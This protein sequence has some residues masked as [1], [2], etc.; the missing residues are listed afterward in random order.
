MSLRLDGLNPL[1][2]MGVTPYQPPNLV[3]QSRSPVPNDSKNVNLGTIWMVST[4]SLQEVWMLM[5]LSGGVATWVQLYP[6]SGAGATEFPTDSGTANEVG[7]ILNI[8][9]DGQHIT[10]S[11]AGNTVTIT[12]NGDDIESID[13]DDGMAFPAAGVISIF[14]GPN[15]N[16][17]GAGSTVTVSLNESIILPVTSSD[18]SSGVISINNLPFMHSYGADTNAFYGAL[19]GNFTLTP[20]TAN[21]NTGIGGAAL[22]SLTDGSS[23]T[24][25]GAGALLSCTTGSGNTTVGEG[26]GID[27][28]TGS[29][30]IAV[31]PTALQHLTTGSGNICIGNNV[32][33]AYTSSESN[34]II[35]GANTGVITESDTIRV[36]IDQTSCYVQGIYGASTGGSAQTVIIDPAGKLGTFGG[37][38]AGVKTTIYTSDD[39][40]VKDIRTAYIKVY[41]WNGGSGGGSGFCTNGSTPQGVGGMGGPMMGG[42]YFEGP[43]LFFPATLNVTVGQGGAGGASQTLAST[44]GNDGT[45]G[46]LSKFGTYMRTSINTILNVGFGGGSV[47]DGQS[48]NWGIAPVTGIGFGYTTQNGLSYGAQNNSVTT[49]SFNLSGRIRG[50][51]PVALSYQTPIS[52]SPAV[53]NVLMSGTEGGT[54]G[55]FTPFVGPTSFEGINGGNIYALPDDSN[56]N[57]VNVLAGGLGGRT[58][59]SPAYNGG[60][61]NDYLIGASSIGFIMG[62]TGGGG[63]CSKNNGAPDAGNGGNGG[64]PGGSGGGGGCTTNGSISG[65]GGDGA[66]GQVIV[67]E[68]F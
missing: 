52:G 24:A 21:T 48:N 62:G 67:L 14:G 55:T 15:I 49:I 45:P 66:D 65:A 8:F 50:L 17:S 34:N 40:W 41:A 27:I 4:E 33:S 30:N 31:G 61:G 35:I 38:G 10:T 54:G 64:F 58:T 25:V 18:Q 1:S 5:S 11:G 28:T 56:P 37:S 57:G 6:G 13:T 60:D 22:F 2:Y 23:N 39:V 29:D 36:G 32:A 44:K 68:F 43:S 42:F 46:T 12:F 63:G 7:G 3:V 16:T 26:A 19:A 9:G 47:G 20:V 53:W 51:D 59:G